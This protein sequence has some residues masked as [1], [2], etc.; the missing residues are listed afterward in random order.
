ML[1][2]GYQS[3]KKFSL[4]AIDEGLYLHGKDANNPR[5]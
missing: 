2:K 3:L 1:I 5:N 4:E